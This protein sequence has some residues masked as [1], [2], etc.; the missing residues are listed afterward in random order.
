ME[1]EVQVPTETRRQLY[2]YEGSPATAALCVI[3]MHLLGSSKIG[4]FH[5]SGRNSATRVWLPEDAV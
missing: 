2:K 4:G 3:L 5:F 1:Y